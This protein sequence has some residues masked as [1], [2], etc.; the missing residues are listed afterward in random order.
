MC[1][2]SSLVSCGG[3]V[4]VRMI[5]EKHPILWLI[6]RRQ[7]ISVPSR[8]ISGRKNILMLLW[9]SLSIA[10]FSSQFYSFLFLLACSRCNTL[11]S[12][13]RDGKIQPG[14]REYQGLRSAVCET[15]DEPSSP[16][17]LS[18]LFPEWEQNQSPQPGLDSSL[19]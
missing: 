2:N 8:L 13:H 18:K 1:A 9:G 5:F 3:R 4:G 10:H 12:R 14:K 6:L 17:L 19:W 7:R 11:S 15:V 16:H